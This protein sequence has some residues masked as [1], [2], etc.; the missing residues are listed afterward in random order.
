M[1]KLALLCVLALITVMLPMNSVL[2]EQAAPVRVYGLVGPTGMSLAPLIAEDDPAYEY[3]LAAAPEE[4]VGKQVIVV[5]NL[6]PAT[7]RGEVS[8]GM[9]L[10]ASTAK[11]PRELSVLTLD[12][13]IPPGSKVK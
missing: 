9:L 12:R 5:A 1:K 2:L 13:P 4:L 10:A 3:S 7:L 8:N 11:D 6:K